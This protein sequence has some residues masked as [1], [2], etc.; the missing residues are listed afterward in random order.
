MGEV[1]IAM[2]VHGIKFAHSG[3]LKSLQSKSVHIF[4]I[5]LGHILAAWEGTRD[6]QQ[7]ILMGDIAITYSLQESSAL[8]YRII[9]KCVTFHVPTTRDGQCQIGSERFTKIV[10]TCCK[11]K[12][13]LDHMILIRHSWSWRTNY[14]AQIVNNSMTRNRSFSLAVGRNRQL[15]GVHQWI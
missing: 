11:N 7:R 14:N 13:L 3:P 2:A 15:S 6:Y 1:K 12:R 9:H 10:R 4:L 5:N 8:C